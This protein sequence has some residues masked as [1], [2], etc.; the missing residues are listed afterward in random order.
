MRGAHKVSLSLK[1]LVR[2]EDHLKGE[3][4]DSPLRTNLWKVP[5]APAAFNSVATW[6]GVSVCRVVILPE[7][8]FAIP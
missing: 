6:A 8:S 3:T 1:G 4:R 7:P 2:S 5:Y